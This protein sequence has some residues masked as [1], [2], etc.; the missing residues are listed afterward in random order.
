MK[1]LFVVFLLILIPASAYGFYQSAIVIDVE[2]KPGESET[3][4]WALKS[5][6]DVTQTVGITSYL[7][8][9]EL[10][11]YEKEIV[12]E[13]NIWKFVLITISIPEDYPSGY[14]KPVVHATQKGTNDGPMIFN[15]VMVKEIKITVL[16]DESQYKLDLQIGKKDHTRNVLGDLTF[17]NGTLADFTATFYNQKGELSFSGNLTSADSED[18][19]LQNGA[20]I[21]VESIT[22]GIAHDREFDLSFTP[23][24]HTDAFDVS[25][26]IYT[27][28][29]ENGTIYRTVPIQSGTL[30][31][32]D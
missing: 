15:I 17:T 11:S 13:P 10:L 20:T 14:Y 29:S 12:L 6:L 26:S 1:Y 27:I 28:H 7:Q 25:G 19:M 31:L 32:L 16:P 22:N 9:K 24:F 5:T 23:I 18:E 30:T 21:Q 4:R 2:L 8:G 3:V